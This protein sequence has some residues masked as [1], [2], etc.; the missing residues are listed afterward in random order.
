[1]LSKKI[2]LSLVAILILLLLFT[3][4]TKTSAPLEETVEIEGI[5]YSFYTG[6]G[7]Y[8]F[9]KDGVALRKYDNDPNGRAYSDTW[10]SDGKTVTITE[11]LTKR[12]VVYTIYKNYL[13]PEVYSFPKEVPAGDTFDATFVNDIDPD[14]TLSFAKDGS[15]SLTNA[16]ERHGTYTREDEIIT[17]H[18]PDIT[19]RFLIYDNKLNNSVY[20]KAS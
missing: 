5:F 7:S 4:C 9:Q 8:E 12:A 15:V 3:A 18:F 11:P 10:E 19:F 1:M 14:A 16:K 20:Y 17:L 6:E 2:H 13:V